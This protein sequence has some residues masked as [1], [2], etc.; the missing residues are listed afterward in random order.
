[1][2][3]IYFE[4]LDAKWHGFA[5][6][7]LAGIPDERRAICH[8]AFLVGAVTICSILPLR[9][10]DRTTAAV[11]E[12]FAEVE[13]ACGQEAA[14]VQRARAARATKAP[15]RRSRRPEK[16]LS[17]KSGDAGSDPEPT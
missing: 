9:T 6:I 7:A 8:A 10:G 17:G 16:V 12:F 5:E 2:S 1:M 11:E 15:K 3:S 4:K 13:A 14:L